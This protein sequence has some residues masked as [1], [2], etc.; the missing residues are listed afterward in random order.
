MTKQD[1]IINEEQA[2]RFAIHLNKAEN[3]FAFLSRIEEHMPLIVGIPELEITMKRLCAVIRNDALHTMKAALS[4]A[5]DG[6][7]KKPDDPE[8]PG[9]GK[10]H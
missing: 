9:S 5:D 4:V 1:V 10:L 6:D 8:E 7:D 2:Q 3:L